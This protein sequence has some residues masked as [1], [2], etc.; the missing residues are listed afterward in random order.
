MTIPPARPLRAVV[1][2]F[3]DTLFTHPDGTGLL[4]ARGWTAAEAEAAIE[5]AWGESKTADALTKHRDR[6]PESHRRGWLELLGAIERR[7]PGMAEILYEKTILT[8]SWV[9]YPDTAPVLRRLRQLGIPVQVLSNV[10]EP[11]APLFERHGLEGAVDGYTLS[12]QEGREKPDPEL[13]R[14]ACR[15][16]GTDAGETLM[17]GDSYLA[18][19]AAAQIGMPVLILPMVPRGSVRGLGRAV[20]LVAAPGA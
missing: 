6:D 2:D 18:D 7:S 19:G 4:V 16:L 1:F 17:V 12:Y 5:D 15:A 10:A 8:P 11:L 20:D 13:F 9:P 3:G 14:I